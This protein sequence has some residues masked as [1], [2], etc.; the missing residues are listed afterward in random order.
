VRGR[1]LF[2]DDETSLL[3]LLSL[4]H[5]FLYGMC[6]SLDANQRNHV[7]HKNQG[8]LRRIESLQQ[9]PELSREQG[10][11]LAG[12]Q[13]KGDP[14][15]A[16]L[17]AAAHIDFKAQHNHA[18]GVLANSA[19]ERSCSTPHVFYLDG[20]DGATS[21]ALLQAGFDPEHLNVANEYQ[22]TIEALEQQYGLTQ[23]HV[24]RAEKVL[25]NLK[26]IPFVGAY[27]DGC[28]GTTGPV[29]EMVEA[30]L[31][32]KLATTMCIGF[33]LTNADPSGRSLVDRIQD[34]TRA[35]KDLAQAKNYSMSHVGDDPK[36]FGVDPMRQYDTTTTCWLWLEQ[37][38]C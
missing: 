32:G 10:A 35:C 30:L 2:P 34:V 8:R 23:C 6:F 3:H 20:Q 38:D 7:R 15:D 33:T 24:G 25:V 29:I 22:E 5:L 37:T 14:F 9:Q 28:G 36:R 1:E 18:F 17:F 19:A 26:E 31:T 11:E 27:L 16:S 21:N 12:L 13:S 4:Q